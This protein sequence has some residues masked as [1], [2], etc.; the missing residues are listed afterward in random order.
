MVKNRIALLL[1]LL[2]VLCAAQVKVHRVGENDGLADKQGFYYSLPQTHFRVDITVE[3][4]ENFR[5]PYAEYAGKYLGLEDVIQSDNNQY[6]IL[7]I[8]L[9]TLQSPDP[10]QYFFA[11][12]DDKAIKEGKSVLV[13]VSEKGILQSYNIHALVADNEEDGNVIIHSAGKSVPVFEYYAGANRVQVTDTIIRKVVVDTLVA[14]RV[15]FNKRWELK[16]DEKKAEEAAGQIQRL[17]ESRF[18][19]ITG[20]QEIPYEAGAIRYMD[21]SLQGVLDEYVS[22][23]TGV[24]FKSNIVF[25]FSVL[26]QPG[27]DDEILLPVCMF[28]EQFGI[29][30]L[31]SIAGTKIFLRMKRSGTSA[32]V[33]A[34]ADIRQGSSKTDKGFYYRIPETVQVSIEPSYRA[35]VEGFFTVAQ[36][37]KV[38]WLAPAVTLLELHPETGAIKTLIMK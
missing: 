19:L 37:G 20:Y 11:E 7:D 14:E 1:C 23:F 26:P 18:N 24:S 10:A 28:S 12:L 32:Q 3:K 34:S 38:T 8:R 16:S 33:S 35:P 5:G 17:R 36:F 25:S 9:S 15:Y 2:P 27:E 4:T 31:N 30:D 6:N 21:Q 13:S 22:L 29:R